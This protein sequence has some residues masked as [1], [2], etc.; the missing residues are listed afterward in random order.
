[1]TYFSIDYRSP[2]SG[3][4]QIVFPKQTWASSMILV[5]AGDDNPE[6]NP[7]Y[8]ETKYFPHN[9]WE[10]ETREKARNFFEELFAKY[11]V[12]YVYDAEM[13]YDGDAPSDLGH[14]NYSTNL[15]LDNIFNK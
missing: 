3:V 15:W 9:L 4:G 10:V 5:T 12:E 11:N 2:P 7:Y 6:P 1:M 13:N 8:K 14:S